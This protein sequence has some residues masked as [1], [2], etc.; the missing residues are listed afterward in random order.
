MLGQAGKR[1]LAILSTPVFTVSSYAN[2][3]A[4]T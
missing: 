1:D 2:Q 4:G 3:E